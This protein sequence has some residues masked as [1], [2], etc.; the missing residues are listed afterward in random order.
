MGII[1]RERGEC[2]EKRKWERERGE[3]GKRKWERD[4]KRN[5]YEREREDS[6]GR[7]E[8]VFYFFIFIGKFLF[9]SGV[10]MEVNIHLLTYITS[11]EPN[12]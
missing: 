11:K 3:F 1:G 4:Q 5:I 7:R 2:L 8:K 9:E 12:I 10:H 6:T